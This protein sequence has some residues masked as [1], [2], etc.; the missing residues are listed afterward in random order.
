MHPLPPSTPNRADAQPLRSG[1]S[2][3]ALR[4]F[5]NRLEK[6]FR[7]WSRWAQR[8]DVGAFRFYDRDLPEFPVAIDAYVPAD[9]TSGL[10]VQATELDTGWVQGPGE[11]AGWLRDL[12]AT[13]AARVAVPREQIVVKRRARRPG[14]TRPVTT[15]LNRAPF[16]VVEQGLRF[17]VDLA[18][19]LD[20]GL[21]LDHR[22]MRAMVRARAQ[23]RRMLNLFGYTGSFTVYAAAGGAVDSV[24]VDL[25]HT[26]LAWAE[27]NFVANGLDLARHRRARADVLRWLEEAALRRE[28]Y[29]LVVLD[30]P[31]FS[32]SKSMRADL[33]VQRDHRGLVD[34]CL[35][36]LAPGGE[37]YFSTNLRTFALD[38]ALAARGRN[39]TAQTRAADFRDPRVHHAFRFAAPS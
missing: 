8:R 35:G 32:N 14:G 17:W 38:P 18:G 37:L 3:E 26:Y 36:L 30:P 10:Q 20:T 29:D 11:H 13:V 33:D 12:V 28:R 21:F 34:A 4:A 24:T 7:H 15:R 39:I 9:A 6:N 19:H 22:A 5:G 23:G 31:A 25:S 27:R 16:L 2:P 1:A